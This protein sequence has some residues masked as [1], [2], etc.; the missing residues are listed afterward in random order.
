MWILCNREWQQNWRWTTPTFTKEKHYLHAE[1]SNV[2]IKQAY[3]TY[4]SID[5]VGK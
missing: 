1:I 5:H 2:K 3:I 4:D